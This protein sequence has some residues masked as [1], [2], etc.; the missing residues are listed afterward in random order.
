MYGLIPSDRLIPLMKSLDELSERALRALSCDRVFFSVAHLDKLISLGSSSAEK[1]DLQSRSHLMS[2]TVCRLTLE[3]EELQVIENAAS[4]SRVQ[5]VPDVQN[6]S[7]SGY[8]GVPFRDPKGE[9]LGAICGISASERTWSNLEICYVE[10]LS[11]E[12]ES[13][14][15]AEL[16]FVETS[17]TNEINDH[18]DKLIVALSISSTVATS[19]YDNEGQLVF[20]NKL[21]S[22]QLNHSTICT[23]LNLEPLRSAFDK[24]QR[25]HSDL[26]E[27]STDVLNSNEKFECTVR[28]ETLRSFEVGLSKAPNG[29]TILKWHP[30]N[31]SLH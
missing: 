21:L 30:V 26:A 19:I 27:G 18:F 8:L 3:T 4:D 1:F 5:E 23:A 13:M 7:I 6:G 24:S 9:V 14:F 12:V 29:Y 31:L 28:N 16:H 11:K 25:F 17:L 2:D 10:A 20:A 15:L 22:E